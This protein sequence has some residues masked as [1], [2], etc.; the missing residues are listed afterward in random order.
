M[1]RSRAANGCSDHKTVELKD[2]RGVS[3]INRIR[4]PDFRRA[5]LGLF[6]DQLG[7]IPQETKR[8]KGPREA[9]SSSR[10]T[11]L[12][13]QEWFSPMCRSQTPQNAGMDEQGAPD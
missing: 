12:R 3:R 7:K 4:I 9:R 13:A 5:D 10:T 11:F 1:Q 8:S 6:K 2:Q